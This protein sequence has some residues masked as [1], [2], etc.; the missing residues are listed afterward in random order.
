MTE[1]QT[2]PVPQYLVR[3]THPDPNIGVQQ[4]RIDADDQDNAA[5]VARKW[6]A[7][8]HN[9]LRYLDAPAE[10]V[11]EDAPEPEGV[12]TLDEPE[13]PNVEAGGASPEQGAG[14]A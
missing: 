8:A 9:D 6:L 1:Q 5:D 11:P 10:L 4:V 13:P 3:V 12:G 14:G 2:N 7:D